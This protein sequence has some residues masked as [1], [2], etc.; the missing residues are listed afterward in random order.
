[1]CVWVFDGPP[2]NLD[3]VSGRWELVQVIFLFY[4][5]PTEYELSSEES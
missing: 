3:S 1:M 5:P 2:S 4:I